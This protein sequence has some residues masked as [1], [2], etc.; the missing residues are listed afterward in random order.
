MFQPQ[1]KT[2]F[3][4]MLK[5]L[6][7]RL[8]MITNQLKVCFQKNLKMNLVYGGLRKDQVMIFIIKG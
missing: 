3:Q 7:K 5:Q 1:I 6:L 8:P 4:T 2:P